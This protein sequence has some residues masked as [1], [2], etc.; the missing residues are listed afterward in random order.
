MLRDITLRC[1]RCTLTAE[2]KIELPHWIPSEAECVPL[3]WTCSLCAAQ[4]SM[5]Q[6]LPTRRTEPTKRRMRDRLA[7]LV[8]PGIIA[9]SVILW[10]YLAIQ[11]AWNHALFASIVSQVFVI[12]ATL[13]PPRKGNARE[14]T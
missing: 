5:D 14:S 2:A 3:G 7:K 12:I 11:A 6:A 8:M 10:S 1:S 9:I 13:G 4:A